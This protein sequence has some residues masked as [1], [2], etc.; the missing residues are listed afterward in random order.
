MIFCRLVFDCGRQSN[1]EFVMQPV[2]RCTAACPLWYKSGRGQKLTWRASVEHVHFGPESR[3]C[4][5]PRLSSVLCQERTFSKG[6]NS[7]RLTQSS[8]AIE[9]CQP[10]PSTTQ[11]ASAVE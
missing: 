11:I 4:R 1:V 6:K 2:F 10:S 9:T 8:L 3:H 7:V 5:D